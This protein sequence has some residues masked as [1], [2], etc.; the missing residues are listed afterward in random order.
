[1]TFHKIPFVYIVTSMT[2]GLILGYIFDATIYILELTA[3]IS[4]VLFFLKSKWRELIAICSLFIL[5]G[6]LME[7]STKTGI[8]VEPLSTVIL[9]VSELEDSNKVWKKG[10]G[11][12]THYRNQG[13]YK[14]AN[15]KLLFY[16]NSNVLK[17][18]MRILSVIEIEDIVNSNNPG[19][20]DAKLFWRSKGIDQM[21]FLTDNDFSVLEV[22]QPSILE[23]IAN[24]SRHF[25]IDAIDQNF[26]RDHAGILKALLLG[27]KGDLSTEVRDHFANAGAMHLLA[28]SGLHVGIIAFILLFIFKQAPK[29]ISNLTAHIIVVVLLWGYALITGFSP[30]VTRAVLMFS[31][32]IL[33]RLAKGQYQPINVLFFAAFISILIEPNVIYDIGFQLSY[34]AVLGIF[35]F[36]TPLEKIVQTKIKPMRW[37]WQGTCIGL[38]AQLTTL[39]LT[40]YYFHQFPNYFAISN[41]GV[42]LM[43]SSLIFTALLFLLTSQVSVIKVFV[44]FILGSLLSLLIGFV[45]WVD[46]LTGSVAYGFDIG[47]LQILLYSASLILLSLTTNI[48]WLKFMGVGAIILFVGWIQ[49]DRYSNMTESHLMVLNTSSPVLVVRDEGK[50]YCIT[51]EPELKKKDLIALSDYRRIY[52]SQMRI[53]VLKP[54]ETL[55]LENEIRKIEVQITEF[56]MLIEGLECQIQLFTKSMTPMIR[57]EEAFNVTMSYLAEKGS[58]SLSEGA[59]KLPLK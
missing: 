18:G 25:V 26:K 12:I 36:Y 21:A 31:L 7:E 5:L 39:P 41:I 10:I 8:I 6:I 54:A 9:E 30:S 20:F 46:E 24:H 52:P 59:I 53:E 15:N 22:E 35:L 50:A 58:H 2:L 29:R 42:M 19:S 56:G 37:L 57:N 34:L 14:K 28:V 40:L 51:T 4:V 13:E 33:S 55:L 38:S 23:T 32:L 47:F 16:T 27:D 11:E 49:L 45:G 43:A 3:L 44:V 1:M 17:S 48:K